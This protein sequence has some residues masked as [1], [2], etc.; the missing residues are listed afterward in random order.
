MAGVLNNKILVGFALA[1]VFLGSFAVA[2]NF[3]PGWY[4]CPQIECECGPNGVNLRSPLTTI[5]QKLN[6][7]FEIMGYEFLYPQR[8]VNRCA[9][10]LFKFNETH[11]FNADVCPKDLTDSE[12]KEMR[13]A[14]S[15]YP[16]SVESEAYYYTSDLHYL[17]YSPGSEQTD[18]V[19]PEVKFISRLISL[20]EN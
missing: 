17:L 13:R 18:G 8:L 9:R 15:S 12:I 16:F 10:M 14:T 7:D 11:T 6:F 19:Y 1:V 3:F 5:R 2:R 4:A 20:I